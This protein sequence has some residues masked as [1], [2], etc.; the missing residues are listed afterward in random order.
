MH[1]RSRLHT[2]RGVDDPMKRH[3]PAPERTS[4]DPFSRSIS[5]RIRTQTLMFVRVRKSMPSR[6]ILLGSLGGGL[7]LYE[8][9]TGA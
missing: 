7:T 4:C 5:G 6:D 1:P 2:Y 3:A 8:R 9:N